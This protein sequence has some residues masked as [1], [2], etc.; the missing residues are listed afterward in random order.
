MG[1]IILNPKLQKQSIFKKKNVAPKVVPLYFFLRSNETFQYIIL[2]S[3]QVFLKGPK[4]VVSV[5]CR[6]KI[7][8]RGMEKAKKKH[9][10]P[11]NAT[12]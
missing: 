3:F 1:E 11:Q 7:I 12:Y 6:R 9:A 2:N 8:S 10:P 5:I 4:A